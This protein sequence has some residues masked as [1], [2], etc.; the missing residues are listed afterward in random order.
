MPLATCSQLL[1]PA[2]KGP[3]LVGDSLC[4]IGLQ[5]R[6]DGF[7]ITHSPRAGSGDAAQVLS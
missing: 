2:E 4:V 1:V 6:G 3:G 7:G 5:L